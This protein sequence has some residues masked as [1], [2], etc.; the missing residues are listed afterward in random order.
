[1]EPHRRLE[2]VDTLLEEA[3]QK[4]AFWARAFATPDMAR[5]E[6]QYSVQGMPRS[7][8]Q[9]NAQAEQEC[10]ENVVK[11]L[12]A[13]RSNLEQIELSELQRGVLVKRA[14]G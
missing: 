5:E 9:Y 7:P 8:E 4:I 10:W 12:T 1:M 13:V 2:L 14:G 3:T 6:R 11:G